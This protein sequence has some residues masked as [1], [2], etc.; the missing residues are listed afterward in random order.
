MERISRS[1]DE[2][3]QLFFFFGG[4]GGGGEGWHIGTK[5]KNLQISDVQRLA[6]LKRESQEFI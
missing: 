3:P 1:R 2:S 5:E 6:S 4:G